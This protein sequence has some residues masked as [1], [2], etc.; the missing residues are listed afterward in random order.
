MRLDVIIYQVQVHD[1]LFTDLLHSSLILTR[2]INLLLWF[3]AFWAYIDKQSANKLTELRV[4]KS[5]T[6]SAYGAIT[7]VVSC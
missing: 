5:Y 7:N 6:T 1:A 3:D 4:L 2:F